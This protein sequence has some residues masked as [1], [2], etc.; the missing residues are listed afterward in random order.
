MVL[1]VLEGH[2]VCFGVELCQEQAVAQ[3]LGERIGKLV[4]RQF[5]EHGLRKKLVQTI[6]PPRRR[7]P[8]LPLQFFAQ[9]IAQIVA[10]HGKGLG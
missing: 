7:L 4:E 6:E 3:R 8:F 1:G 10:A 2:R 9:E 5:V